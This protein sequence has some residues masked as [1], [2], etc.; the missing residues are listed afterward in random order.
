VVSNM[1][2][3]HFTVV[4]LY[5]CCI[6]LLHS[7]AADVVFPIHR[8]LIYYSLK[9]RRMSLSLLWE[10]CIAA[11]LKEVFYAHSGSAHTIR[12]YS[13][14]LQRFFKHSAKSPE[15]CT[16]E[17]VIDF[18]AMRTPAG[19]PPSHNTRN[20]RLN[21][22]RGFY[23]FAAH[24]TVY[25][26]YGQPYK[27]YQG[28]NP[29]EGLHRTRVEVRPR[30]LTEDEVK[31]FF[32]V[33]PR[34]TI[35]GLRDRCLFLFFLTTAR[36]LSEIAHLTWGDIVYGTVTDEQGSRAGWTYR[37]TGKGRGG[38]QDSA[39]LPEPA[40]LALWEYLEAAARL[41][42][43]E[44]DDPLFIAVLSPNGGGLPIDPYRPLSNG[45]ILRI[46]I[47]YAQKAGIDRV[48]MNVH[49]WRHTSVRHRYDLGQDIRSLQR[50]LRHSSL[51]TTDI[52]LRAMDV[53]ADNGAALLMGKFGGL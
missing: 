35:R 47:E 43:I 10:N 49:I 17:D 44:P 52:Y 18:I 4:I 38:Q 46:A 5:T 13:G 16:R 14:I 31:R 21:V 20:Y 30:Y 32:S 33:I 42:T 41:E 7:S 6:P 19:T 50:L 2:S 37:F 1:H 15:H 23:K 51:A 22:V 27:L 3:F 45:S 48:K 12:D 8:P 25:D 28:E 24:Y 36:R 39:E 11:Y 26:G 29:A 53:T 34:D 40:R 9:V